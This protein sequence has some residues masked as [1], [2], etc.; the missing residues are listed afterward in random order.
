MWVGAW[1]GGK[2]LGVLM[3]GV[4]VDLNKHVERQSG[5]FCQGRKVVPMR[6]G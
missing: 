6:G 5:G 1:D 4:D 2:M 3:L